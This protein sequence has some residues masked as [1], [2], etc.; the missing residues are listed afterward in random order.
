MVSRAFGYAVTRNSY[1][2]RTRDGGQ[3]WDVRHLK[4]TGNV[5]GHPE[6][7]Q[8]IDIVD[9]QFA[10]AAGLGGIVFKTEDGG[11]TWQPIG[12]P[13]LP[14]LFDI[15]DVR[16]TNRQ[17]GWVVGVDNDLGHYRSIYRTTDGGQSW[18]LIV[19]LQAAVQ[20]NAVDF[21]GNSG[22]IV[23]PRSYL[24]R[25]TDGGN[26]WQQVNLPYGNVTNLAFTDVGFATEQIGWMIGTLGYVLR[27][28][29]GGQSWVRQNLDTSEDLTAL[30][31]VSANE[32]WIAGLQGNVY[33]TT[34]GGQSWV[35][36][37]IGY[38]FELG[39][40]AMHGTPG[41]HLVGGGYAGFLAVRQRGERVNASSFSVPFGRIFSGNLS[42]LQRSD[43]QYLLLESRTPTQTGNP[44]IQLVVEG[45]ASLRAWARM[46]RGT[47]ERLPAD[48]CQASD[49]AVQLCHESMGV[50]GGAIRGSIFRFT[51]GDL[52]GGTCTL[53]SG[54]HGACARSY[55]LVQGRYGDY[56]AV[57]CV[58]GLC[59]VEPA[60]ARC[61]G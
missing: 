61:T 47:L 11:E 12:Y 50:S 10:V 25:T 20:Y 48:R 34:D 53:H 13:T 24:L 35:R 45:T 15:Y 56:R 40:L 54:G 21:V 39:L 17:T 37:S 41:G 19:P 33:H 5:F 4:V 6:G 26:S 42:G 38:P 36:E 29:N 30:Y 28:T 55:Q 49:G 57:A 46:V 52:C 58:G 14:G 16:F 60:A 7:L 44:Y 51:L 32:A 2:L 43:D 3:H 23:G 22:W 27:S 1:L 18:Q 31:V 8:A 9:S 59:A